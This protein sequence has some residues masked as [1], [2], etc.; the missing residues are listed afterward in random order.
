MDLV[1]ELDAVDG[2]EAGA[3][4]RD[5]HA[6]KGTTERGGDDRGRVI[7][8]SGLQW[9]T[10]RPALERRVL[11]A[12]TGQTVEEAYRCTHSWWSSRISPAAS[13]RSARRSESAA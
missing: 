7:W 3:R 13:P 9:K 1:P 4:C 10:S 11:S 8:G 2:R 6:P 12:R 5:R